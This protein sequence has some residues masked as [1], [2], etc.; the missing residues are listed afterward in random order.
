M[1]HIEAIM[2]REAL[3]EAAEEG[4]RVAELAVLVAEADYK[5]VEEVEGMVLWGLEM[6]AR[7]IKAAMGLPTAREEDTMAVVEEED[8]TVAV[9]EESAITLSA[10]AVGAPAMSAVVQT[11]RVPRCCKA[12][13]DPAPVRCSP[14][15]PLSVPM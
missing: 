8:T 4:W 11:Q 15:R 14:R 1:A 5:R 2:V 7:N 10:E 6:W 9:E 3:V 13:R 12:P